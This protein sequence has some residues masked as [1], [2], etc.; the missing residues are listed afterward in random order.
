VVF[1]VLQLWQ[2][3][4]T[5]AEVG[6]EVGELRRSQ[7]EEAGTEKLVG[8]RGGGARGAHDRYCACSPLGEEV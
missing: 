8:S 7:E 2:W 3:T 5:G 4:D 6:T 1:R